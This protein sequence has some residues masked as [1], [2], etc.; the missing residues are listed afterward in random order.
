MKIK[1]TGTFGEWLINNL[2]LLMLD[3]ITGGLGTIYHVYWAQK[4][5]ASHLEIEKEK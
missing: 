2:G 3:V 5:F 1:F 4:Y